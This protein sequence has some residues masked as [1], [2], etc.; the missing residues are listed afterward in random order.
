MKG[1]FAKIE[2]DVKIQDRRLRRCPTI[3]IPEGVVSERD[4]ALKVIVPALRNMAANLMADFG[5]NVAQIGEFT[6]TAEQVRANP[7]LG[8]VLIRAAAG[9]MPPL[10]E[11][12]KRF[13]SGN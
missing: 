9:D 3:E 2:L 7:E 6:F 11:E 4:V 5:V 13:L 8:D 1:V 10:S 12:Q